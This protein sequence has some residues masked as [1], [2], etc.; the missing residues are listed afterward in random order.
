MYVEGKMAKHEQ[1]SKLEERFD[2]F[3]HVN[4]N[5]WKTVCTS[6]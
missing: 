6:S 3:E 5:P 2:D 1:A 4:I